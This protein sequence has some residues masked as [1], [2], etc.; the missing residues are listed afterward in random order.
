[1]P[2]RYVDVL[3]RE[4]KPGMHPDFQSE[5]VYISGSHPH[6]GKPHQGWSGQETI[7]KREIYQGEVRIKK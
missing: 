2:P 6:L 3:Y 4:V 1:M 7:V 5:V